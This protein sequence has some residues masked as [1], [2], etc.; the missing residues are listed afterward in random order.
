MF[1]AFAEMLVV[2]DPKMPQASSPKTNA[3][4]APSTTQTLGLVTRTYLSRSSGLCRRLRLLVE[5]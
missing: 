5:D 4:T 2:T 1:T 3:S